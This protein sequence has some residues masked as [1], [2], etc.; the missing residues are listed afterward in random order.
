MISGNEQRLRFAQR[1]NGKGRR[2]R[3]KGEREGERRVQKRKAK[4]NACG[5]LSHEPTRKRHRSYDASAHPAVGQL[6]NFFSALFAPLPPCFLSL[7]LVF[8]F[9]V[10]I[11]PPAIYE[12]SER[13]SAGSFISKW[14]YGMMLLYIFNGIPRTGPLHLRSSRRGHCGRY[15]RWNN[16]YCP[17]IALHCSFCDLTLR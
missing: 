1:W 5:P 12:P 8:V 17:S 10:D 14:P 6:E 2:R 7:S 3:Q 15:V 16:I 11:H 4:S 9:F 13:H